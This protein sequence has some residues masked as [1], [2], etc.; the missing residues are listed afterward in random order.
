MAG[1]SGA[2][3]CSAA[4]VK[5]GAMCAA[6]RHG[7]ADCA[8]KTDAKIRGQ[9]DGKERQEAETEVSPAHLIRCVP[10]LYAY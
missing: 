5:G 1:F 9:K 8:V 3:G 2:S 4:E 7:A 10:R 6:S